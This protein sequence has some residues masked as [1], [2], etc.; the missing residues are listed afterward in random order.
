MSMKVK[1]L[2]N[3]LEE[4]DP[5]QEVF[6]APLVFIPILQLNADD[7]TLSDREVE[8]ISAPFERYSIAQVGLMTD[9]RDGV[10]KRK[11]YIVLGYDTDGQSETSTSPE[12]VNWKIYLITAAAMFSIRRN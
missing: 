1:D 5:E 7:E 6:A 9:L 3:K 8:K 11:Q 2:I 12:F 10:E 4:A